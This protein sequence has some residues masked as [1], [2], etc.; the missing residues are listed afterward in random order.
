MRAAALTNIGKFD[1]VEVEK[2]EIVHDDDVLVRVLRVGICGSDIHYFKTGRIGDQRVEFPFIIGHEAAGVVEECGKKVKSLAPGQT[3][4]IEPAISCMKCDQCL[5]GRFHTC[6]NNMFLGCPGQL[7]G[8][9][10]EYVVIPAHNCF[11]VTNGMSL[12]EAVITEPLSIGVYSVK[13]SQILKGQNAVIVGFGPIGMSVLLVLK[14]AGI[15]DIIVTERN[16]S[17][18][19]LAKQ[20]GVDGVMNPDESNFKIKIKALAE[21]GY[22]F[23]FE[24]SG[25]PEALPAAYDLLKPGGKLVVLG[26]PDD[27][28]LQM[29]I[30]LLRRKEIDLINIRRQLNCV[31]DAID[32]MGKRRVD[33]SNMVTHYFSLDEVQKAFDLVAGY[34]D[35]VMKAM[36]NVAE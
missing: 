11:P 1:L 18:I 30:H 17:R 6:R 19:A 16:P 28:F 33:I 7:S 27:H 12:D 3:V 29:P 25:N 36:V 20:E 22:D 4:A 13:R 34:K 24:C 23:V 5:A 26:I 8:C 31:Q 14:A 15:N 21:P 2:P 35:G 32:L 9:L 10:Q